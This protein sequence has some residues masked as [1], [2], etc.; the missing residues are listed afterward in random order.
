MA[1]PRRGATSAAAQVALDVKTAWARP[2]GERVHAG[3]EPR[4]S[5]CVLFKSISRGPS[6]SLCEKLRAVV[7]S[8]CT[9]FAAPHVVPQKAS[10]VR[11]YERQGLPQRRRRGLPDHHLHAH[12]QLAVLQPQVLKRVE[13]R[14][15]RGRDILGQG[16]GL[17]PRAAL[18]HAAP[19]GATSRGGPA[20]LCPRASR[21]YPPGGSNPRL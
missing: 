10:T 11:G 7:A 17:V 13:H 1:Q 16:R 9:N 18:V 12:R 5:R 15:H 20:P 8:R 21:V 3:S 14:G 19:H 6:W 4:I 2:G